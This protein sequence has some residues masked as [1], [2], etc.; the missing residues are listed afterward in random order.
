MELVDSHCHLDMLPEPH[1]KHLDELME[2]AKNAG[3]KYFLC[4]SV[5]LSDLSEVLAPANHYNNVYATVGV[6]PNEEVPEEPTVDKLIELANHPKV[7]A[8]GETGLDYY[9]SSGELDWQRDR[10]RVH[11]R[12]AKQLKIPLVIHSRQ[13][14]DDTIQI[15]KEENAKEVSGVMHCFTEDWKMAEQALDLGFYISFSGIVSFKNAPSVQDVAKKMPMERMLIETDSP[16]L[17]PEPF[18]GQKN[19]PAYVRQVAEAVAR[20]RGIRVEEVAE[21]TTNNFFE[22]FWKARREGV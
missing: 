2:N 5:N 6:H 15:L 17:A 20:L 3:V 9:R 8:I 14:P 1:H 11:I 22:L 18:R 10:F 16:Y 12:A 19:Q 21:Y 7:V 13:A 4:V